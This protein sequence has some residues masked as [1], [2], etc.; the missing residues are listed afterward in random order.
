MMNFRHLNA[1]ASHAAAGRYTGIARGLYLSGGA[2]NAEE[3]GDDAHS[4]AHRI[5]VSDE[6]RN[7]PVLALKLIKK[8]TSSDEAIKTLASSPR[9]ISEFTNRKMA[10]VCPGWE[11][12]DEEGMNMAAFLHS[13]SHSDGNGYLA[14]IR[15]A[16]KALEK[17]VEP[18]TA[19]DFNLMVEH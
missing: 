4:D 2:D 19:E 18:M 3:A 12:L 6:A 15:A 13:M 9:H 11:L 16:Q 7:N 1:T 5:A 14:G 8:K 17:Y 10:A